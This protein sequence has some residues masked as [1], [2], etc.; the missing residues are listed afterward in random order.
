MEAGGWVSQKY[1]FG[2]CAIRKYCFVKYGCGNG[3]GKYG[4]ADPKNHPEIH[5]KS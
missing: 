1:S 5:Q 3:F 2:K 4:F